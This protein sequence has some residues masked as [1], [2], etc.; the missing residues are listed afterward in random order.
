MPLCR[1]YKRPDGSVAIYQ[2]NPRLKHDGESDAAFLA[3][4]ARDAPKKDPSLKG[5]P[6]E[7]FDHDDVRVRIAAARKNGE[8]KAEHVWAAITADD[9]PKRK[10]KKQ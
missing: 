3:R 9:K 8:L 10:T 7:D 6:H 4:L 1:V 2:P 5:L